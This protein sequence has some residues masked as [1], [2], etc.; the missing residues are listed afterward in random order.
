MTGAP[1]VTRQALAT[2]AGH[3]TEG[4]NTIIGSLRDLKANMEKV[5]PELDVHVY[6]L[7]NSL[8]CSL[9]ECILVN[10]QNVDNFV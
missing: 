1:T 2:L 6:D 8:L 7:Q 4:V 5:P 9:L 3:Q 10:N